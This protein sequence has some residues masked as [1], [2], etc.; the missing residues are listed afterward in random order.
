M[1]RWWYK[2][3]ELVQTRALNVAQRG[4]SA[5]DSRIQ[6]NVFAATRSIEFHRLALRDADDDR[7]NVFQIASTE[8]DFVLSRSWNCIFWLAQ[9][10]DVIHCV[11]TLGASYRFGHSRF[12]HKKGLEAGGRVG[13]EAP[14][15]GGGILTGPKPLVKLCFPSLLTCLSPASSQPNFFFVHLGSPRVHFS[16]PTGHVLVDSPRCCKSGRSAGRPQAIMPRPGLQREEK[17]QR[18]APNLHT[19]VQLAQLNPA[20]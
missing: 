15:K 18:S 3:G 8:C 12:V 16:W 4:Q 20:A 1:S 2:P 7:C 9:Q 10:N 6:V 11:W 17:G 14:Q 19:R 5:L 13:M